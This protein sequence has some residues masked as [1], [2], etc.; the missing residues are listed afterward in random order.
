M[1]EKY[2]TVGIGMTELG[3]RLE[4]SKT[5]SDISGTVLKPNLKNATDDSSLVERLG[6][7]VKIVKGSFRNIKV[8]TPEDLE[9]ARILVKRR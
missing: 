1:R 7:R 6:H 8:T 2:G 5:L 3:A 9:L 4:A